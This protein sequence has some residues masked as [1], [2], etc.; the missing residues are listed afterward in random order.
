MQRVIVVL[1]VCAALGLAPLLAQQ[2]TTSGPARGALVLVGGGANRDAFIQRF[3]QLAGGSKA[4]IVLIPTTLEDD[5]LTPAGLEQVASSMQNILGVGSVTVMHTRDPKQADSPAFV[6]P[7]QRATGVWI[8]GGNETYLVKAY[9]GTRT[10][11]EIKA[12]LDRGGVVG[13]TSAGAVV[14]GSRLI[15][16]K[17]VPAADGTGGRTVQ[18][19]GTNAGFGLLSNAAVF[20]HWSQRNLEDLVGQALTTQPGLLG[21]GIDEATAAVVQGNQLEV[22]GDGNVGIY[23]GKDH[24]G[25][26]YYKLDPGQRFD[27]DK[28]IA[29][30]ASGARG[31]S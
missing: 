24:A 23:D 2:P 27:L 21:I 25:K 4:R 30:P 12:L 3:V 18:I 26:T 13:G 20:V 9:C 28:R 14:Q 22:L 31:Q 19:R 11:K 10:E 5:R 29:V 7:L 8:L 6:E 1:V 17:I 16:G 15:D